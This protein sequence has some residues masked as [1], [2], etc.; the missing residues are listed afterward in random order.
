[1]KVKDLIQKLQEVDPEAE[2]LIEDESYGILKVQDFTLGVVTEVIPK[3]W[4]LKEQ[5]EFIVNSDQS[6]PYNAVML[7]NW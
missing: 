6:Q 5:I 7:D 3:D 1:M 2:V 4:P